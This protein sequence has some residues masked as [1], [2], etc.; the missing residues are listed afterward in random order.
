MIPGLFPTVQICFLGPFC[1]VL[2]SLL[3][4]RFLWI[5]GVKFILHSCDPLP[6]DITQPVQAQKRS[7]LYF[8]AIKSFIGFSFVGRILSFLLPFF[9]WFGIV[10]YF[11]KAII[12]AVVNSMV[13]T[14]WDGDGCKLLEALSLLLPG[15]ALH[16]LVQVGRQFFYY[17]SLVMFYNFF[18]ASNFLNY[19]LNHTFF[20][21]FESTRPVK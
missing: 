9:F 11:R 6:A 20:F 14:S 16:L 5:T 18:T 21:F 7:W 2:L 3:A 13:K 4:S 12:G 15:P 1:I 8:E 10:I 17:I 19:P